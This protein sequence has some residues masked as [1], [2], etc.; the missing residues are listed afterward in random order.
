MYIFQLANVLNDD[1]HYIDSFELKYFIPLMAI[2]IP[3]IYLIRAQIFNRINSVNKSTQEL[4]DEMR[5]K[6]LSFI[7]KIKQYF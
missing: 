4:E 6:P 2:I 5:I 1:L 3:S 7:E